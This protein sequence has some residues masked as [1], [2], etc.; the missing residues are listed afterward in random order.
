ME[1]AAAADVGEDQPPIGQPSIHTLLHILQV[2]VVYICI[3]LV[4]CDVCDAYATVHEGCMQS[5][6]YRIVDVVTLY[7]LRRRREGCNFDWLVALGCSALST[8]DFV[9]TGAL[10]II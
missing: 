7:A 2:R 1:R 3:S 9:L 10:C 8:R 5:A 6:L 4:C